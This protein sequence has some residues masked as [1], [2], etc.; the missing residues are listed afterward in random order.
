MLYQVTLVLYIF[1]CAILIGLVLLNQ[2]QNSSAGSAF[3]SGASQTVFGSQ[4][5]NTF[6]FKLIACFGG[7]FFICSVALT[8]MAGSKPEQSI[9]EQNKLGFT[10]PQASKPVDVNKK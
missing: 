5:S 9:Q 7:L 2:P 1:V 3:G 10:V 8:Y 6:I 4:G